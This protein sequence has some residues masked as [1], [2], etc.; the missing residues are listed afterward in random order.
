MLVVDST[1]TDT[2]INHLLALRTARVRH[3]PAPGVSMD[4]ALRLG[5]HGLVRS[6]ARGGVEITD[7]GMTY[8]EGWFLFCQALGC[9]GVLRRWKLLSPMHG[10][11]H[12]EDPPLEHEQIDGGSRWTITCPK[13]EHRNV[14]QEREAPT[15]TSH[16]TI[17]ETLPPKTA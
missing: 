8:L 4:V 6:D 2:D 16:Y 9:D 15:R 10:G 5:T 7:S 11:K 17:A 13:C 12:P 1:L 14:L 3:A